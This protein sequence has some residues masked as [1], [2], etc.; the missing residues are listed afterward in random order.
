MGNRSS[1]SPRRDPPLFR[2]P[3]GGV[4]VDG[5]AATVN[6]FSHTPCHIPAQSTTRPRRLSHRRVRRCVSGP[7]SSQTL[8]PPPHRTQGTSSIHPDL[9]DL[10]RSFTG[11]LASEGRIRGDEGGPSPIPPY[12]LVA[13]T[14]NLKM[15]PQ[16]QP[17]RLFHRSLG[18]VPC[19]SNNTSWSYGGNTRP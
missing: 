6:P 15:Q 4:F 12:S 9:Q 10:D 8:Q 13:H 16:L 3:M 14:E 17:H 18:A 5:M 2:I 11:V 1:P 19:D 7:S